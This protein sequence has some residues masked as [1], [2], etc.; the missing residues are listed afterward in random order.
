MANSVPE[1]HGA[2]E[3]TVE[4]TDMSREYAK[5]A[6][7]TFR[8]AVKLP[9]PATA[10]QVT[11]WIGYETDFRSAISGDNPLK[12]FDLNASSVFGVTNED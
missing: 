5:D 6:V 10:A 7:F 12:D 11:E 9:I 8:A 4:G 3:L 2:A 1:R